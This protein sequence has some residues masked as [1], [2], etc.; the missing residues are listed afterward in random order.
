M[1]GVEKFRVIDRQA[2][3]VAQ[4]RVDRAFWTECGA[5]SLWHPAIDRGRG[6]CLQAVEAGAKATALDLLSIASGVIDRR[7]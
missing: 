6:E 2:G 5:G 1:Q 3:S 7:F 4:H